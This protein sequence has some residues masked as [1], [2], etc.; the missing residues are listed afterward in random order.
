MK[1]E[2]IIKLDKPPGCPVES[3]EL[4]MQIGQ[5][6]QKKIATYKRLSR[7]YVSSPFAEVASWYSAP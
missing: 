1:I 6:R 4:N 5:I 7:S 3:Q 2:D